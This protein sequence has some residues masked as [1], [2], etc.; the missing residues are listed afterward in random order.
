MLTR[1]AILCISILLLAPS[2][3]E[4]SE[5]SEERQENISLSISEFVQTE[6]K[7]ATSPIFTKVVQN[8]APLLQHTPIVPRGKFYIIRDYIIQLRKILI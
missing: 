2:C 6:N 7:K 5:V 4:A 1:L 3:V 8:Q